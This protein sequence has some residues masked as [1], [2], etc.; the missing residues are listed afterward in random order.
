MGSFVK[1]HH[2]TVGLDFKLSSNFYELAIE[3]F[4]LRFVKAMQ[5]RGSPAVA[6]MSKHCQGYVHI[7]VE[8]HR[9]GQTVEVKEIDAD[10]EAILHTITSGVAGDEVPGTGVEVVGHKEGRLGMSQAVHSHLPDGASVPT[11]CCRLVH[12]ADVLVAAFGD[13]DHRSTPG[14]GWEGMEVT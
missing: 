4:G 14:R 2:N 10:A 1:P 11:E 6:P 8:P 13:I 3:L 5:L 7:H 9:T 12:I